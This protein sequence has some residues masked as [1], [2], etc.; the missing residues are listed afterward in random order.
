ME[1][2]TEY[3]VQKFYQYAG[4]PRHKKLANVYEGCCPICREGHSWGKKRRLYYITSD[5]AICCHNCGWYSN[6]L[7][8]VQEVTQLSFN[9]IVK[10]IASFDTV[11]IQDVDLKKEIKTNTEHLPVDSINQFNEQEYDYYKH[12]PIVREAIRFIQGRRLHTAVNKPKTLW[13]SLT[14]FIHKR[15]VV[16]P[17]YDENNKI[18]YYQSRGIF[19]KDLKERPKYLSKINS[20]KT[21]FNLNNID[22]NSDNIFILEGPIDS[23][24]LKNSVAV[25][26][27]QENSN[28]MFTGKQGD[29]M[30][31]YT[32]FKRIWVLDSQWCDSASM[33]KTKKLIDIGESVFIWPK[34]VGTN[35]KDL[36]EFLFPGFIIYK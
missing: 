19:D 24:F 23:F 20:D 28:N 5:N 32:L 17:F 16:L 1:L 11:S 25:A 10:E 15:R 26:G 6:T 22:N 36:N 14:D 35:F 31:R 27:I 4:Y 18:V 34:D 3:V 29:Q 8:W 21:L 7:K 33:Q 12:Q 13:I 30:K 2:P 9:E